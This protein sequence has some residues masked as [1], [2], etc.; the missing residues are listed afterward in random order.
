MEYAFPSQKGRGCKYITEKSYSDILKKVS[1]DSEI[2][3]ESITG[4]SL[5]KTYANR[6]YKSTHDLEYVRKALGH[7]SVQI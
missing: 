3:L 6:L 1:L 4:H 7:K 2:N 5:R